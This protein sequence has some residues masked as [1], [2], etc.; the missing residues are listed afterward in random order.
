MLQQHRS[1]LPGDGERDQVGAAV[2]AVELTVPPHPHL[3]RHQVPRAQR[4]SLLLPQPGEP[5]GRP[6]VLHLR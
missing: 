4:G 1:R 6:V 3:H 5:E 2:P